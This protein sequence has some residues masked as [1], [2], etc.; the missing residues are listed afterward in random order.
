MSTNTPHSDWT[1]V[2][3]AVNR[4]RQPQ[5]N[6]HGGCSRVTTGGRAA[7]LYAVALVARRA[8]AARQEQRRRGTLVL[9]CHR[10]SQG[11]EEALHLIRHWQAAVLEADLTEETLP[12]AVRDVHAG[13]PGLG[14]RRGGFVDDAAGRQ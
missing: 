8:A 7:V 13:P 5:R 9:L 12:R 11:L 1:R 4:R 2:S 6:M 3:T 14:A 10:L